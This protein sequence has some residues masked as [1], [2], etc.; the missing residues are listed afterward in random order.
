MPHCS[1]EY[2][3]VT[4]HDFDSLLCLRRLYGNDPRSLVRTF[5]F[6]GKLTASQK[7]RLPKGLRETLKIVSA[8]DSAAWLEALYLLE[9]GRD[10]LPNKDARAMTVEATAPHITVN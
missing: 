10:K 4:A 8:G 9:S 1:I 5:R 2:A 6:D 3:T 7:R